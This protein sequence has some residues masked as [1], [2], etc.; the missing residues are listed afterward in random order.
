MARE[1]VGSDLGQFRFPDGTFDRIEALGVKRSE[2]VRDAVLDAL[3]RGSAS[4]RP[5]EFSG[6]DRRLSEPPAVAK[7]SASPSQV[8][9]AKRPERKSGVGRWD[10]Q[11][12]VLEAYL[13]KRSSDARSAAR[14][15]GWNEGLVERVALELSGDGVIRFERGLMVHVSG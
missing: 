2:F 10:A 12:P 13:R 6:L 7:V 3:L 15:L 5:R 4:S 11:K 1:K 8:W 14:D 9:K